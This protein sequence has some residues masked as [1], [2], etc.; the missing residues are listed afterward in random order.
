[1]PAAS[2]L[3]LVGAKTVLVYSSVTKYPLSNARVQQKRLH[4][5]VSA[6]T[7]NLFGSAV[8][9]FLLDDEQQDNRV[10]LTIPSCSRRSKHST[11][12]YQLGMRE[13]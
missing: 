9:V 6:Y 8:Y 13:L 11:T 1:M 2:L 7:C 4:V 12:V 5:C 3:L 10:L